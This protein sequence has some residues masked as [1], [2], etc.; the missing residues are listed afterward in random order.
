MVVGCAPSA[1]ALVR[2]D[3]RGVLAGGW[4]TLDGTMQQLQRLLWIGNVFHHWLFTR[5]A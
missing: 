5:M 2:G 3:Q 4:G 1:E